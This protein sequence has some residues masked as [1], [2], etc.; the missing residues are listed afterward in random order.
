MNNRKLVRVQEKG[1][2]TIPT[3]IRKKLRLKRGD[4]VAVMETPDGVFI[5]PQQVVVTKA[6]DSIGDILKEKGLSLEELIASGRQAR[7][8]ILQETY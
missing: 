5:T 8:D 4:L 2:V 1:Q 7:G 6:L 3:K